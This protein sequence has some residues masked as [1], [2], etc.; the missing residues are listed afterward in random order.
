MKRTILSCIAFCFIT[1]SLL[2]QKNLDIAL[3]H[4]QTSDIEVKNENTTEAK[5]YIFK[6]YGSIPV[7]QKTSDEE[8]YLGGELSAKWNTFNQNYTHVYDQSIGFGNSIVEIVKP[9]VFNAINKVNNYFKKVLKTNTVNKEMA[10]RTLSHMLDC[11]N[12]I[13][14]EEK[15][16]EFERKISKAKT[17][18]E[19]IRLF[20]Q[21]QIEI[22]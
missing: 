20:N 1:S 6:V 11:A 9:S 16:D 2:A 14:F 4:K 15:T 17:P 10:I 21:V 19:I 22:L 13:C 5:E 7:S 12:V 18:E 3:N 8:H